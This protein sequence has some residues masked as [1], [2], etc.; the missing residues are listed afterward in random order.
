MLLAEVLRVWSTTWCPE[1]DANGENH[2]CKS[3]GV[4]VPPVVRFLPFRSAT[5][6]FLTILVPI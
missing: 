4:S 5:C 3:Q 6:V 2:Y 1:S